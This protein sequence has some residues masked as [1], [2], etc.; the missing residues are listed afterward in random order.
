MTIA[1]LNQIEMTTPRIDNVSNQSERFTQKIQYFQ[2][3]NRPANEL[4]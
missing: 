4:R 1:V 2:S 3:N